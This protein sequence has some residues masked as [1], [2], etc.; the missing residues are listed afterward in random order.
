MAVYAVEDVDVYSSIMQVSAAGGYHRAR[1]GNSMGRLHG[2]IVQQGQTTEPF[3]L[4]RVSTTGG[5]N[6]K[7]QGN[8][9]SRLH[10]V[11]DGFGNQQGKGDV[12]VIG[13]NPSTIITV[14]RSITSKLKTPIR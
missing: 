5:S 7:L 3:S 14:S 4:T 6:R 2:M 12:V 11:L 13:I 10:G 8:G 9:V 1:Q